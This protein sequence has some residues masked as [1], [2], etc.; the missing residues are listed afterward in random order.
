MNHRA[1]ATVLC[2]A[3]LA[4]WPAPGA[5]QELVSL[6]PPGLYASRQYVSSRAMTRPDNRYLRVRTT[7][8]LL[9]RVIASEDGLAVE[10]RYCS[11]EQEPLGKVRTSIGPGFVSAIPAWVSPLTADPDGGPAG[12]RIARHTVVLGA[13]LVDPENDRLPTE[14]DDPRVTDP[15]GDGNPGVTVDVSGFVSGQVYLVQ[16]LVRGLRGTAGPGGRMTGTVEGAGDQVVI[17]AS[18]GILK[19]FTPDFEYNPDPKRNTFV[20]V[21]V[22]EDA[23]C[24]SVLAGRDSLFGED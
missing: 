8:I 12:V 22:P 19:T 5:A 1:R 23:T 6:V 13:H 18:S 17:G 3:L 7:G 9:H 4:G 10:S 14:E 16:R 20:W 15:D 11:I 21:P 24:A 2:L